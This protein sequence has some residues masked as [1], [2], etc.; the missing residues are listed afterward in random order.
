[1]AWN[2]LFAGDTFR[3][4]CKGALLRKANGAAGWTSEQAFRYMR[5]FP[6]AELWLV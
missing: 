3:V 6:D 2:V 1:L 4:L 5:R